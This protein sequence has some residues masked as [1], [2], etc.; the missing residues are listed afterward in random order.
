MRNCSPA[1][2]APRRRSAGMATIGLILTVGFV[3][4]VT[5]VALLQLCVYNRRLATRDET[6]AQTF[7][8]AEA[9]VQRLELDAWVQFRDTKKFNWHDTNYAGASALLPRGLT[10]AN[11]P[12]DTAY[13]PA[14]ARR[15]AA[16]VV[17]YAVTDSY[18]RDLVVRSVGWL[19]LNG[20]G[21][22]APDG[23]EPASAVVQRVRLKLDR[24]GVFDYV[25]FVN[26]YGWMTGF[27]SST[28]W[29]NGDMRAN[30]DFNIDGG[31]V[32]GQIIA[33]YNAN[34]KNGAGA[35][36]A[37]GVASV[38]NT[39]NFTNADYTSKLGTDA[40]MKQARQA[41]SAS[42]HGATTS[43]QFKKW[44]EVLYNQVADPS[45]KQLNRQHFGSEISDV[46]STRQLTNQATILPKINTKTVTMPDLSDITRYRDVSSTWTDTKAIYLDGTAN[47]NAGQ[48]PYIEVWDANQNKYKRLTGQS[49]DPIGVISGSAALLGDDAHPIKI[50]G[51]VTIM[52]DVAIKGTVEG[53]GTLYTGRN[54]HVIGDV[55]YKDPPSF[56]GSDPD[57]IDKANEKRTVLALCARG[58]VM[59]GNVQNFSTNPLQYMKP[60]FTKD[61]RDDS[62][63]Q[64]IAA[65]DATANDTGYTMQ[66]GGTPKK[67]QSLFGNT[68]INSNSSAINRIDAVLYTNNCVGGLVGGTNGFTVNGALICKDEA[69]VANLNGKRMTL[70]YDTRIKERSIDQKPLIDIDLPRTPNLY[71]TGWTE[72]NP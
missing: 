15:F 58:S 19:D 62:T 20:S 65:F 70:N 28:L 46:N 1:A 9:G 11:L 49:G 35:W 57:V 13:T 26:N 61:R 22:A 67:Y 40:Y 32:N 50:H 31:V 30:G 38:S 4:I 47:P 54:V 7:N 41:Y 69:M 45:V 14:V 48:P 51:P 52:G 25:Y 16:A 3:L 71:G 24:S 6:R 36:G 10:A 39:S 72:V 66:G 29:V 64:T 55:V 33:S 17:G 68:W 63:G 5:G 23:G 44:K 60:P 59:M 12:A 43:D 8:L 42:A 37:A 34:L 18:T 21:G 53:Q 27:T 56:T 2:F